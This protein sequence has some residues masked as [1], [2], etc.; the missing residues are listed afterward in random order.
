MI[1]VVS[2]LPFLLLGI[3]SPQT[4][5]RPSPRQLPFGNEL[6]QL[7]AQSPFLPDESRTLGLCGMVWEHKTG[8]P[9]HKQPWQAKISVI[10]SAVSWWW[11]L[12]G[13][14]VRVK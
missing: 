10:V 7:L 2:C 6:S 13:K 11:G 3:C 4:H 1:P 5:W 12:R 8:T 14:E 9:Y